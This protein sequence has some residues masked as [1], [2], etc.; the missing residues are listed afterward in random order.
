MICVNDEHSE[1]TDS[2]IMFKVEE[3]SNV[4]CISDEHFSKALSPIIVTDEGIDICVND[5]I[6]IQLGK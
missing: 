1:K 6:Y 4:I 2:Q 5:V 3:L